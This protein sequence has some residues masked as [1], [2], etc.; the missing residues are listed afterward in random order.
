MYKGISGIVDREDYLVGRKIDKTFEL[1]DKEENP[2]SHRSDLSIIERL[3]S[4]EEAAILSKNDLTTKMREDPLF[5]IKMKQIEQRK[6]I[7][8]NPMKLKQ[9]EEALKESLEKDKKKHK[10]KFKKHKNKKSKKSH[11]RYSNSES[12]EDSDQSDSSRDKKK[13]KHRIRVSDSDSE[14]GDLRKRKRKHAVHEYSSD[15]RHSDLDQYTR[16]RKHRNGSQSFQNSKE[17]S[18]HSKH[19]RN[20]NDN[21]YK[22]SSKSLHSKHISSQSARADSKTSRKS[23]ISEEEM[24]KKREEMMNNARWREETRSETVSKLKQ[25]ENE[26]DQKLKQSTQCAQFIKPLLSSIAT[27]SSI[28]SSLKQKR[29]KLQRGLD[30]MNVHFARKN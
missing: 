19:Y 16:K 4:S 18:D 24:R 1:I 8:Q 14:G 10:K 20:N 12:D 27:S 2:S 13:R 6:N 9:L 23:K 29:F 30:T 15:S 21:H 28:E 5:E 7:L 26:E 17:S 11:H 25:L 3:E 22:S